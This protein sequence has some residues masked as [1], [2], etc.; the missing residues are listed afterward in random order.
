MCFG[1]VVYGL[2]Q[3]EVRIAHV[4]V[5]TADTSLVVIVKDVLRGTYLGIIPRDSIFFYPSESIHTSIL[6]MYPNIAAVSLFRDGFTKLSIKVSNRVPIG[7][8]CG[9]AASSTPSNS[10][11]HDVIPTVDNQCYLFDAGGFVYATATETFFNVDGAPAALSESNPDKTLTSFVL[12]DALEVNT[13]SPIG[14]TLKDANQL[15]TVFDFARQLS[16]V[17]PL[18][19]V[20]VIREDEVDFFLTTGP[21]IT[22]LLRDEQNAFTALVSAK[23]SLSL[24]DPT[25]EYIDL[26]F[27][28]KIYWKRTPSPKEQK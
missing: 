3:P 4:D 21:R 10:L 22:Y 13:S 7:H 2:W 8:W 24:S 18:V 5:D 26:R 16:S 19:S 17:G 28:G 6:S 15:P 14:A 25:L 20:V 23:E 11:L 12:F 9:F 1:A 27:P